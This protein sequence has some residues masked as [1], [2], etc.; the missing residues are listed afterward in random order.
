MNLIHLYENVTVLFKDSPILAGI[1]SLWGITIIT[2]LL[3]TVPLK[4]INFFKNS[5]NLYF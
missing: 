3:K 1:I 2:Y 4:I 5:I